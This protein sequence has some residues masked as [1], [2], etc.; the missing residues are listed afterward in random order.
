MKII[1]QQ[2]MM[3]VNLLLNVYKMNNFK[4][5]LELIHI[6]VFVKINFNKMKKNIIGKIQINYYYKVFMV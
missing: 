2:H 1:F 6:F 4:K 3:Q 5:L